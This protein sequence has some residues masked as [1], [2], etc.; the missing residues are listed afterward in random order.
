MTGRGKHD[1][2]TR[3]GPPDEHMVGGHTPS[4]DEIVL[5]DVTVHI[6]RMATGSYWIGIRGKD[7]LWVAA[8]ITTPGRG[9]CDL[10]LQEMEHADG[11]R[12][13]DGVLP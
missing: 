12:V 6:E 13:D 3:D 11:V 1:R 8:N 10:W 9:R 4:L 7:G 5:T 2:I